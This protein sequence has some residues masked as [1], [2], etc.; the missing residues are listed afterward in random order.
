MPS[1]TPSL[2]LSV[3]D[4]A[5]MLGC[6][7]RTVQRLIGRGVLQGLTLP[8]GRKLWLMRDDV[9]AT[10]NNLRATARARKKAARDTRAA[11]FQMWLDL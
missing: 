4:T 8:G 6:S 3:Y 9:E 10:A 7:P 2:L 5:Q 1:A 11:L